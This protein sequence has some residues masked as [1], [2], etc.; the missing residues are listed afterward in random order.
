VVISAASLAYSSVAMLLTCCLSG[1]SFF[2]LLGLIIDTLF[3]A[4]MIGVAVLNRDARHG[5]LP[6]AGTTCRLYVATFA[7]AIISLVAYLINAGVSFM[8]RREKKVD[9]YSHKPHY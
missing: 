2:A 7:L 8:L 1:I 4:A 3:F 9:K 5:C 6:D